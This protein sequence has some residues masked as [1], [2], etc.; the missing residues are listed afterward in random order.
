MLLVERTL[1]IKLGHLVGT[2]V[3]PRLLMATPLLRITTVKRPLSRNSVC[4]G[5]MHLLR[6]EWTRAPA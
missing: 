3:P 5:H 1:R 4:P 6:Q 2:P